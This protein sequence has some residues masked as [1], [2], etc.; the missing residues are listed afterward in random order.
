MDLLPRAFR[1]YQEHSEAGAV[2]AHCSL[3]KDRTGLFL[4]YALMLELGLDADAAFTRVRGIRPVALTADG[5]EELCHQ[6]LRALEP[7][8][9]AAT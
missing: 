2:V 6:V 8:V 4:S 3:G 1:W 9:R 5:W 7:P